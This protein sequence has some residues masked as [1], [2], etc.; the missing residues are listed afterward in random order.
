MKSYEAVLGL[1]GTLCAL[2]LT[3][4]ILVSQETSTQGSA[5][6]HL[7]IT[8]EAVRGDGDVPT[9][10]PGDV[11]VKQGKTFLKVNQLIP[12]QGDNAPLQLF[13]LVDDTLGSG[14]VGNNLNAFGTS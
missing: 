12:A 14:V 11:K 5:Q 7:V 10:Q 1:L 2:T 6:V 13:I 4:P 3:T 8:N 9:L